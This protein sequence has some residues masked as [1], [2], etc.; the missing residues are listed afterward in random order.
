MSSGPRWASGAGWATCLRLIDIRGLLRLIRVVRL[1]LPPSVPILYRDAI[2]RIF[3]Q[4]GF[5][6][7][8]EFEQM[9]RQ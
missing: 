7:T 6:G 3:R 9:G 2:L 5:G 8:Q 4:N 1:F